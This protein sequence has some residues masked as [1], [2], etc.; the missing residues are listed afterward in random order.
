L[1]DFAFEAL[2]AATLAIAWTIEFASA[3]SM[4]PH[5]GLIANPFI[6]KLGWRFAPI[7]LLLSLLPFYNPVLG[8]LVLGPSLHIATSN[9]ERVWLVRSIGETRFLALLEDAARATSLK[10]AVASTLGA[11][12]LVAVGGGALMFLSLRR[13]G[14]WSYW[15]GYGLVYYGLAVG[16][17]RTA[18]VFKLRRRSQPLPTQG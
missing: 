9:L 8:V 12:V 13:T 5:M 4:S 14:D 3:R 1:S 2:L 10:V 15:F 11:G 7:G 6:A 16:L 18:F 17:M